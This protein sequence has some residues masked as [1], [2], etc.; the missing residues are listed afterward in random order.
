[1]PGIEDG[2]TLRN[3]VPQNLVTLGYFFDKLEN[4]A[5]LQLLR[6]ENFFAHPPAPERDEENRTIAFQ[7]WPQSR[8][9]ARMGK[10]DAVQEFVLTIALEIPKTENVAVQQDLV[11]VA[12]T[13]PPA[14]A[15]KLVPR[16]T[17]W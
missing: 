2:K 7:P 11:D 14:L 17:L 1:T 5:W 16:L 12:I 6:K 13:L 10:I 8:F 15:V 3:K 4:P 9:L